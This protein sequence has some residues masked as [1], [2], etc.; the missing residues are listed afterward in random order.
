MADNKDAKREHAANIT[1]RMERLRATDRVKDQ[2]RLAQ[3][4]I[5]ERKARRGG[6]ITGSG[7][8]AAAKEFAKLN[9]SFRLMGKTM[10]DYSVTTQT[11]L[12]TI[13]ELTKITQE[14]E[15]SSAKAQREMLDDVNT[16]IRILRE[17]EGHTDPDESPILAAALQTQKLLKENSGVMSRFNDFIGNQLISGLGA[18]VGVLGDSPLLA[19]GVQFAG[20]VMQNRREKKE[21]QQATMR[22]AV[23]DKVGREMDTAIEGEGFIKD[24]SPDVVATEMAEAVKK[25]MTD[26]L[27][28]MIIQENDPKVREELEL[29]FEALAGDKGVVDVLRDIESQLVE[30]WPEE[31]TILLDRVADMI[32][33]GNVEAISQFK[34]Q[35]R[36]AEE[37]RR[38]R[39]A[40]LMGPTK[41]EVKEEEK[42]EGFKIGGIPFTLTGMGVWGFIKT[43]FKGLFAALAFMFTPKKWVAAFSKLAATRFGKLATSI[44]RGITG[45]IRMIF[46]AK[47]LGFI[48]KRAL[49]IA[50]IGYSLFEG[51]K[52]A[53]DEWKE[54]GSISEAV[55]AFFGQVAETM[56]FGLLKKEKLEEWGSNMGLWLSDKLHEF[57][58]WFESLPLFKHLKDFGNTISGLFEKI[59]NIDPRDFLPEG[60]ISFLERMNIIDTVEE[61]RTEDLADA[62]D[63]RE[64]ARA[65]RVLGE[66]DVEDYMDNLDREI[67]AEAKRRDMSVDEVKAERQLEV[68]GGQN[69]VAF[70]AQSPA[71][72]LESAVS[73]QQMATPQM[74]Q[75][76]QA[77]MMKIDLQERSAQRQEEEKRKSQQPVTAISST[78]NNQHN[79]TVIGGG[80]PSDDDH[81][82]NRYENSQRIG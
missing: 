79:T 53:I 33:S 23:R 73:A 51:G 37:A 6:D 19:M 36:D 81:M 56:T 11:E 71:A 5:D 39:K 32:Q 61:N 58:V 43:M 4:L 76:R 67:K 63:D 16:Q 40:Q 42:D 72:E 44:F 66:K 46:S 24:N 52:A 28:E 18:M 9:E 14:A 80:G 13:E 41:R 29:I 7:G 78:Q 75:L 21:K 10:G 1:E 20:N 25:G 17:V 45:A 74:D 3:L 50:A 26:E 70:P 30:G 38:D 54:S 65:A 22:Q 48:L 15:F 69:V 8:Q 34:K 47:A 2:S 60:T 12:D 49:P 64:R 31:Q 68:V 62:F 55:E 59:G 77:E 82:M 27:K 57:S 35:Q